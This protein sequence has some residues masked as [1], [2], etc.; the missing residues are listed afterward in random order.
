MNTMQDKDVKPL[1]NEKGER[2]GDWSSNDDIS[3]NKR[4]YVNNILHGH[5]LYL[6]NPYLIENSYYAK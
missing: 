4:Y 1:F 6:L 3:K 2:H 5:Y